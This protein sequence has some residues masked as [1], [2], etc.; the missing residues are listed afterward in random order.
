MLETNGKNEFKD[1]KFNIWEWSAPFLQTADEIL[2]KLKELKLEGRVIKSLYSI[3]KAYDWTEEWIFDQVCHA[4]EIM[5]PSERKA[6]KNKK[7]FLP[8]DVYIAR[9]AG[10]YGPFLIEFED[11]DV[12][13]IVFQNARGIRLEMNSLPKD[14]TSD[15]PCNF[16]PNVL[17]DDI[18]GREILSCEVTMST[19]RPEECDLYGDDM[20][21]YPAHFYITYEDGDVIYP[22]RRLHLFPSFDEG[23][24]E[25]LDYS[26]EVM[27]IHAPDVKKVVE[28][29][30][31]K[32]ILNS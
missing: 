31:D 6:L 29:F 20:D 25:L 11:G 10:I 22:K 4:I 13:A 23:Y 32:K 5:K 16:H 3:S 21:F 26:N 30:I 27:K 1:N 12:L 18:I 8:K 2:S 28:G 15:E 19:R 17:F 7:A 24:V 14:M 9:R